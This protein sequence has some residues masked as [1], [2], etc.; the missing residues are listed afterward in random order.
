[1]ASICCELPGSQ[2]V[3][4]GELFAAG[5]KGG[6]HEDIWH[7]I[8][9]EDG[10][11]RLRP[12]WIRSHLKLE[13]FDK[14]FGFENRWR[15][16]INQTADALCGKF[17]HELVDATFVAK[18]RKQDTVAEQVLCCLASRVETI[19]SAKSPNQH[20]TIIK[21]IKHSQVTQACDIPAMTGTAKPL[22]GVQRTCKK[23][24][25]ANVGHGHTQTR[26]EWFTSLVNEGGL[27]KH[28]WV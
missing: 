12:F 22:P 25:G 2:T 24:V 16:N 13:Q 26:D 21:G 7:T 10:F 19:L 17:A 14:V 6:K 9:E 23:K 3:F 5:K 1:V 18:L 8:T 20:P 15:F 11:K 28:E 27:S 4:R